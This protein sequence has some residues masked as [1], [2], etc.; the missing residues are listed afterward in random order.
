MTR[1]SMVHITSPFTCRALLMLAIF[2]SIFCKPQQIV[3]TGL[4]TPDA[5]RL[6]HSP[7]SIGAT[8]GPELLPLGLQWV[9]AAILPLPGGTS[10]WRPVQNEPSFRK[11]SKE[12]EGWTKRTLLNQLEKP[13]GS[14]P[15]QE[16][17]RT[18]CA[19]S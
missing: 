8:G 6:P 13:L 11:E 16:V 18:R 2:R 12:Q 10:G 15:G 1:S 9:S 17:S 4:L 5:V 7:V 19:N 14:G 3:Q